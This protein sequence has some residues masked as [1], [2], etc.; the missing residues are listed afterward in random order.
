MATNSVQ[1]LVADICQGRRNCQE[2]A[3]E[4]IGRADASSDLNAFILTDRRHALEQAGMAQQAVDRG[5]ASP[6]AGVPYAVK[7]IFNVRGLKTS[8]ASRI[9]RG[10]VSP[11]DSTVARKSSDAGMV[12][13]GKT[14]MDEFAMGSSGENSAFGPTLNPWDRSRVTGGSSSGSAAAVAAGIV[15]LALGT[16]T[17]GSVRQPAAFCGICGIK[18]TYGRISRYGMVAFASSFDQ[19]GVFARSAFDLALGTSVLL[20]HDP[21][22]STSLEIGK[23]DLATKLDRDIK[24]MSIGIPEEFFGGGLAPAVSEAVNRAVDAYSNL[25]ANIVNLSMPSLKYSIPAYYVLSSAEASSNLSR[26]DGVRYGLRSDTHDKLVDMYE[27]TR[28]EGFGSE[29]KRRI[30][31]GTYVLSYGYYDAYYRHAQRV[32]HL[33]VNEFNEAFAK[34]DV[35]L[36]P[37]TPNTAFRIGEKTSNP[38]QMYL[39]DIYTISVN[40]AGL[41]G[42]SIPCGMDGAGLPIGL[43][44]IGNR[45]QEAQLLR[46]A[47]QY[48]KATDWHEKRPGNE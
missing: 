10:Y 27:Q 36:G 38:V 31:I 6:L 15:P 45:E 20:G 42:I 43:Q 39:S 37:T 16:D 25:G 18:P 3:E 47:H 26:Y 12:L 33:V 29:V 5:D 9:L 22:D 48:Q 11:Y 41:P 19:A 8:C 13:I 23:E 35:I 1:E 24:G 28:A 34:C 32:R 7:D 21:K 2:T 4:A 44:L 40:L 46:F 17:G 14:N 30:L